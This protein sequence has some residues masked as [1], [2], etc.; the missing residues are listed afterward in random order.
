MHSPPHY[1]FDKLQ[2]ISIHYNYDLD[3]IILPTLLLHV[4]SVVTIHHP[5]EA[6]E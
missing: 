1:F 5:M 4:A 2:P 6:E 3:L